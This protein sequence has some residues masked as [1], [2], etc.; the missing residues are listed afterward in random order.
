MRPGR[1]FLVIIIVLAFL[2]GAVSLVLFVRADWREHAMEFV[3]I[4][5]P[6]DIGVEPQVEMESIDTGPISPIEDLETS[7]ESSAPQEVEYN[8][9]FFLSETSAVCEY[10]TYTFLKEYDPDQDSLNLAFEKMLGTDPENADTDG[11]GVPD[12]LEMAM[13]TSPT[14]PTNTQLWGF[15]E[16]PKEYQQADRDYDGLRD[17]WEELFGLDKYD[18][19][20]D[21]DGFLDG[22]EIIKGFNPLGGGNIEYQA[23]TT[24]EWIE[25]HEAILETTTVLWK[26]P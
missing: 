25:D 1:I 18:E 7:Q 23:K 21:N 2:V 8:E 15:A 20:S 6:E 14:D 26:L 13:R 22:E 19:D 17:E 11:D 9:C 16:L 10:K 5:V 12:G 24:K 4:N 3:G